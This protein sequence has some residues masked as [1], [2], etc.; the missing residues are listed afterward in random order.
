MPPPP[1]LV[2]DDALARS[3][4]SR[5]SDFIGRELSNKPPR[6]F[7]RDKKGYELGPY[8]CYAINTMGDGHD[9]TACLCLNHSHLAVMSCLLLNVETPRTVAWRSRL[10]IQCCGVEGKGNL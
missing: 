10:L 3:A 1:R 6:L 7:E 5:Q 8:R 9:S 2:D 4:R